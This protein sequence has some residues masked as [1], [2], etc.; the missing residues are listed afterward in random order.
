MAPN[1]SST[2]AS[3]DAS[4]DS[5]VAFAYMDFSG[6][7]FGP[8]KLDTCS[9][10]EATDE[11]MG[12][13]ST[14]QKYLVGITA[15]QMMQSLELPDGQQP[16]PRQEHDPVL[17]VAQ[18]RRVVNLAKW[19]ELGI[20]PSLSSSSLLNL[21]AH[22]QDTD[23]LSSETDE[24]QTLLL[25]SLQAQDELNTNLPPPPTSN[26]EE[27]LKVAPSTIPQAGNGLFTQIAIPKGE[28]I[29]YYS[30]YRHDYQSQKRLRDRTYV[31]K[32]Q[33]GYPA[34]N[35]RNDGFVDA[36]PCPEIKARYI[37]DPMEEEKYNVKFEHV[38]REGI[39]YCPVVA[40]RDLVGGEE[41]FVCYGP[42]YWSES[43]MIGG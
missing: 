17:F 32:L 23:L 41:L 1:K 18:T 39:W 38:Q 22:A 16:N 27:Y 2:S 35:R 10:Q 8:D 40:M 7:D 6:V 5:D 13:T 29:C 14:R 4:V 36:L 12:D 3:D 21:T 30:G 33:N 15:N 20:R 37:N 28:T 31:L 19:Y 9:S 25:R 24:L 26:Y 34:S 42:R 11:V 43:R